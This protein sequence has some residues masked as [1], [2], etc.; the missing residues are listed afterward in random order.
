MTHKNS[1]L[2][3]AIVGAIVLIIIGGFIVLNSYNNENNKPAESD[4]NNTNSTYLFIESPDKHAGFV[5]KK[6]EKLNLT[7]NNTNSTPYVEPT[8]KHAEFTYTSTFGEIKLKQIVSPQFKVGEKYFYH[9]F[10]KAPDGGRRIWLPEEYDSVVE[11]IKIDRK[12]KSDYYI[13]K[14]QNVSVD[15]CVLYRIKNGAWEKICI[16]GYTM[17]RRNE[18]GIGET[19]VLDRRIYEGCTI[20]INKENGKRYEVDI[21]FMC[22]VLDEMFAEWMLYIDKGVRWVEKVDYNRSF[23]EENTD[24]IDSSGSYSHTVMYSKTDEKEWTVADV[25]KINERECFKVILLI[26]REDVG[27][28]GKM[29]S[30][31]VVTY[32]VDKEKR[33]LVKKEKRIDGVLTEMIEL[34]NYEKP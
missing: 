21:P 10:M 7:S 5:L 3:A 8:E 28:R 19:V 34:K 1:M 18:K 6:P 11:V 14:S 27:S 16:G 31:E 15:K 13:L 12:N 24:R 30:K 4:L 32:W 25:E 22:P 17:V 20:G 29:I 26:K 2:P 9:M 23:E 33:V